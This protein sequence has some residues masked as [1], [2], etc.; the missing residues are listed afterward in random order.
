MKQDLDIIPAAAEPTD[1]A[2][3][4]E[5]TR[6]YDRAQAGLIAMIEFGARV[7]QCQA[8]IEVSD[9]PKR[10]PGSGGLKGWLAEHCP[11]IPYTNARR[12]RDLAKS[13]A[14]RL[15][16]DAP[17]MIDALESGV[18]EEYEEVAALVEGKSARQLMFSFSAGRGAGRPKGTKNLGDY[19]PISNAEAEEMATVELEGLVQNLG[20][21]F[22]AKRNLK[23]MQI[24]RR[25][26]C[27]M[28]L[29]D[30]ADLLK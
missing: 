20:R 30:M 18:G 10:G 26:A 6:L 25:N 17:K 28:H 3:A 14:Q 21:F 16:M 9:G 29:Q 27:R 5:L 15:E 4:Q 12:Y 22:A 11:T 23:V 24:S 19:T 7:A 1:T 2:V 13:V 8:A